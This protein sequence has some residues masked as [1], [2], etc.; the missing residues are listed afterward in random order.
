MCQLF[1]VRDILPLSIQNFAFVFL[2]ARTSLELQW[3]RKGEEQ[4]LLLSL[5]KDHGPARFLTTGFQ[6]CERINFCNFKFCYGSPNKLI[7]SSLR[8]KHKPS[9]V[10]KLSSSPPSV[11]QEPQTEPGRYQVRSHVKKLT[12]QLCASGQLEQGK[13]AGIGE[14]DYHVFKKNV[15][16]SYK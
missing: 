2:S 8:D 5:Q 16:V 12:N 1:G 13:N 6:N 14:H 3:T 10:T 15:D 7:V 4:I 11:V 9:Q